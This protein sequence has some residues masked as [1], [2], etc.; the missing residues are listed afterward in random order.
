MKDKISK[1]AEESPDSLYVQ[2]YSYFRKA[3]GADDLSCTFG[4]PD[5]EDGGKE[6]TATRYGV[7][8]VCLFNLDDDGKL[9]PLA[10]IIDWRGSIHDSV[11][12]YNRELDP[13]KQKDDWAWRYGKITDVLCPLAILMLHTSQDLCP[14]KRLDPA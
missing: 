3:S 4:E 12:M 7:A 2:D 13:I 5:Q 11:F 14:G 8:S 6:K 10:I 9:E 1:R